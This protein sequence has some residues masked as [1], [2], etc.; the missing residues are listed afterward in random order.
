MSQKTRSRIKAFIERRLPALHTRVVLPWLT[1]RHRRAM[2]RLDAVTALVFERF[3]PVVQDG[4]FKGLKYMREAM[5]SG[6][7]SKILGCY[8]SE[9]QHAVRTEAAVGYEAIVDVG[10]AEGYYAAGFAMASPASTV[11]AYD[12]DE[13]CRTLCATLAGLNGVT[14]RVRVGA[15][16]DHA[17]LNALSERSVFLLSD[18]EGY[19][20][21]LL[22]PSAVPA[23][24]GWN[25]LVELH[26]GLVPGV[27]DAIVARFSATHDIELIDSVRRDPRDVPIS[28]FLPSMQDRFLAVSDR[29]GSWQQWAWMRASSQLLAP[30]R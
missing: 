24:A 10:C 3:G 25:I 29:R 15:A 7:T 27:T 14:S 16:C 28:D 21:Q 19:E 2:Q 26:E 23:M 20:M 22:D 8:E 1:R 13:K 9:I 18:C 30:P 6:L 12:I 17:Q 4:P 11:Y 5:N